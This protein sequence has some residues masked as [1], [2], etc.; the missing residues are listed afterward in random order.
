MLRSWEAGATWL[1]GGCYGAGRRV[2]FLFLGSFSFYIGCKDNE[3]FINRKIFCVFFYGRRCF[4]GFPLCGEGVLRG[5][6]AKNTELGALCGEVWG[7]LC[8]REGRF[9]SE[10]WC[11]A[12]E[13]G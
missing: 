7:T 12:S 4:L 10:R 1:E 3:S 11:F 6:T 8:G 2:L 5:K 9:A 13:R